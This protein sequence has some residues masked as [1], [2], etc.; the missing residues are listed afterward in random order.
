ME[1]I[2][3]YGTGEEVRIG[4][5]VLVMNEF[6]LR[7]TRIFQPLSSDAKDHDCYETGGV[8]IDWGEGGVLYP[9]PTHEDLE[10]MKRS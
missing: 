1:K 8:F 4:D 7:V 3:R 9:D 2:F 10:F 5:H 6:E